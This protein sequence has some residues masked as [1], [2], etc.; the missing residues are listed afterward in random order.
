VAKWR[1]FDERPQ[2]GNGC[3][4]CR[5]NGFKTFHAYHTRNHLKRQ[6]RVINAIGLDI[7]YTTN[8]HNRLHLSHATSMPYQLHATIIPAFV[9]TKRNINI[10]SFHLWHEPC[11]WNQWH[12][13]CKPTFHH[14][15]EYHSLNEWNIFTEPHS[16]IK[17]Y[18]V[19]NFESKTELHSLP[20]SH[21]E[22][23]FHSAWGV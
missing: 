3:K 2:C 11:K 16:V 19:K 22:N 4:N 15:A 23:E 6:Q 8:N 9:Q 12:D 5:L 20:E 7:S 10:I 13:S 17:N 21:S 14:P 18:S 1:D